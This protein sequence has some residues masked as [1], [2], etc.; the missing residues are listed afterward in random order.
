MV[1]TAN[2]NTRWSETSSRQDNF[3]TLIPGFYCSHP[4]TT[5]VVILPWWACPW[6]SQEC[7]TSLLSPGQQILSH[8]L[9]S[10]SLIGCRE[11]AASSKL[12]SGLDLKSPCSWRGVRGPLTFSLAVVFISVRSPLAL[13]IGG[14]KEMVNSHL[15]FLLPSPLSTQK[16]WQRLIKVL[17]THHNLAPS[18]PY[19]LE[20]NKREKPDQTNVFF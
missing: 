6:S 2:L 12:D 8:Q 18:L 10:S 19:Y 14:G 15:T 3:T 13:F 4:K 5:A 17:I 7:P 9:I 11:S 1:F 20:K 16:L